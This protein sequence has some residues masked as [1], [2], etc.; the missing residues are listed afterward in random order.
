MGVGV[1]RPLA[2][3]GLISVLATVTGCQ[4]DAP[5]VATGSS[6]SA[7][8][9]SAP[10]PQVGACYDAAYAPRS[11]W[12]DGT[13]P[14]PCTQTHRAE[15]YHVGTV[16]APANAGQVQAASQQ[17]VDLFATCEAKAKEFLGADW[18]TGRIELLLTLPRPDDWGKGTRSYSCEAVEIDQPGQPSAVRRTS[19]LRGALA[20]PG[21]LSM[22]CFDMR[23]PPTWAPMVPVACDQPH[24]AE[25][26]GAF[27]GK[28]P[29]TGDDEANTEA[30]F[31]SCEPVIDTYVGSP[32]YRRILIGF[33]GWSRQAWDAGQLTA[34]CYAVA[35]EGKRF[36]ASV[37][38]IGTRNPPTV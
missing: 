24:H 35:E 8:A 17:L 33:L 38:G 21:P 11:M 30:A 10:G 36:T 6:A 20:Q 28:L 3:I 2:A 12:A 27:T 31:D 16:D 29:P 1:L 13:P 19:T 5:T 23:N 7:S 34:R 25:Y 22:R 32:N 15:T 14:V 18:H 37:K 9:S 4:E 26:A